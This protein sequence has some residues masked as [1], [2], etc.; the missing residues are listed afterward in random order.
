MRANI[1]ISDEFNPLQPVEDTKAELTPEQIALAKIGVSDGWK[2]FKEY[3]QNRVEV[4]KN[5]LF[6]EDLTG[7]DTSILGQR[8][9]AAQVVVQEFE[10]AINE[11]DRTTKIVREVRS[12]GIQK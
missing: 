7:K 8:L 9:L 10:N 11:I 3:L 6:G 4:Y 2:L 12:N 5:G 1:P